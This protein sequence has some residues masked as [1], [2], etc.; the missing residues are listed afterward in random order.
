MPQSVSYPRCF[1]PYLRY[2]ISTRFKDF[3]PFDGKKLFLLVELTEDQGAR[4][5]LAK[6]LPV[7]FGP[8]GEPTRYVSVRAG[9]AAIDP[10]SYPV[11][12]RFVS[13]VELSLPLKPSRGA[14]TMELEQRWSQASVGDRSSRR[15]LMGI[16]DY[17]CPFAGARFLRNPAHAPAST[18]LFSIWDQD[19]RK[20]PIPVAQGAGN[21]RYFG[22][23]PRDFDYGIEYRR[24]SAVAG[25][26]SQ[27]GL[28]EWM[29]SYSAAGSIDED[30]CY[31]DGDFEPLKGVRSHGAH[32]MDTFAGRVPPS[33]RVGPVT[34]H[35]D[36]PSWRPGSDAAS[37]ANVDLV[38]V[39]FP[40]RCIE[41]HTGV[42]LLNYVR[43]GINY[44]LSCADPN[45]REDI[46]INLSYGPTTGPHDGTALLEE[47]LAAFVAY[48][49][50]NAPGR[51]KL[52]IVVPAGNS[53]L[54]EWH[55]LFKPQ[56][57]ESDHATWI[58]H[59]P[60]D[61]TAV[62]F[63][64]VWMKTANAG[65]VSVSLSSPT[66]AICPVDP[67]IAWSATST[68]WRLEVQPTITTLGAAAAEH[69]DYEIRIAGVGAGAEAH[70]YVA[71]TDP[72]MGVRTGARASHFVDAE[73]Q[74]IRSAAASHTLVD[75]EFDN[76]GSRVSRLGTL[77]GL[78]TGDVK[79]LHVAGGYMFAR[80]RG[81]PYASAGPA[82][83]GPPALRKGPD[84][85]LP[86]DESRALSGVRGGGNRSG[87]VFR[88]IGTSAAAPQLA[89]HVVNGP[90]PLPDS[91]PLPNSNDEAKRGAGNLRPPP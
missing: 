1:G 9:R 56:Q 6:N 32:V 64:E 30:G 66:G 60:P 19:D 37:D 12:E 46:V 88:L 54:S 55:A 7:E 36:P 53:Y 63:A 41:D 58:W 49:D 27:I 83:S 45:R 25:G 35:R 29:Q 69:G 84:F 5:G 61:N 57:N 52:D 91:P 85:A 26:V 14:A 11:W 23:A 22:Q 24:K 86:C 4:D 87:S 76:S 38:F 40:K 71:R 47:T 48:Y 43:D 17:G 72:N 28:D 42:W 51:H 78:G 59:L 18:R 81:S 62:C 70:A 90:M 15:V 2:A 33:S 67:P 39:Q 10:A 89:R 20:Q 50:G 73:W 80:K 74:R 44:V 13:R 79:R 68:L 82:R 3:A 16:L 65:G 75:G 31:A 77:N 8:G 34:D 21:P